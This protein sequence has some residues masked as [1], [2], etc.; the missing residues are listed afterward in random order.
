M[1][2][3]FKLATS[4]MWQ[5]KN[6]LK[7]VTFKAF[8]ARPIIC[9]TRASLLLLEQAHIVHQKVKLV[10]VPEGGDRVHPMPRRHNFLK[11]ELFSHSVSLQWDP[12]HLLP[13]FVRTLI[14]SR[15]CREE[16]HVSQAAGWI[17]KRLQRRR[18]FRRKIFLPAH[19]HSHRH[20][21]ARYY[22]AAPRIVDQQILGEPTSP[23]RETTAFVDNT[24]LVAI[25]SQHPFSFTPD[26]I[27]SQSLL[28]IWSSLAVCYFRCQRLRFQVRSKILRYL[29]ITFCPMA[30]KSTFLCATVTSADC[31][32]S[33][34]QELGILNNMRSQFTFYI[35]RSYMH[36][37]HCIPIKDSYFIFTPL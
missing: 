12:S 15:N 25:Q 9:L 4:K 2:S 8:I 27:F 32:T 26:S 16:G 21:A 1:T 5:F 30:I 19:T 35:H 22:S 6:W 36:S 14:S 29:G 11:S 7:G 37:M 13:P 3:H 20:P 18:T 17:V 33:E 24:R 34:F 10:R 28:N 23:H 31:L